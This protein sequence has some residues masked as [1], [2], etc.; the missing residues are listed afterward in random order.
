ME[1]YFKILVDNWEAIRDEAIEQLNSPNNNFLLDE[2]NLR[3]KGDLKKLNL[4]IRGEKEN[5]NCK[6]SPLTCSL[7]EKIDPMWN[8]FRGDVAFA[9]M[10]S[11]THLWP[12]CGPTNCRLRAHLGLIVPDGT[13]IR[14]ANETRTLSKGNFLIFDDSFENEVWKEGKENCLLLRIDLWHPDLTN[15][16]RNNIFPRSIKSD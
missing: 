4:Y 11:E 7:I 3:E 13:R 9:V 10:S 14:V 6:K 5:E 8:S 15:E 1:I 12:H 16:Q 2:E